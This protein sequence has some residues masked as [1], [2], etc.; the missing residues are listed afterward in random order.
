MCV[1]AVAAVIGGP[2]SAVVIQL[3]GW[4]AIVVPLVRMRTWSGRQRLPWLLC[5]AA[6]GLF[7]LGSIT[8]FVHAGLAGVDE[9]FP[10][11]AD[12]LFLTGYV[13]LI[14]GEL[15]LI[16]F[17]T[18]ET[19][20]DHM[21]DAAIVAA[22]VSLL[23]WAAILAP[24]VRDAGIP[25]AER[26]LNVGYSTL[27]LVL[28]TLTARLAVG[29]GIRNQ[30][31][32]LLAG[33]I[34]LIFITDLLAT[35]D[36]AGTNTER[37]VLALPPFTYVLFAAA[38]LH[39]SMVRLT[40][41]P[42]DQD[43]QLTW[44]R[45]LLLAA[46]LLV[47][48]GVLVWQI[49]RD[50]PID[51]PVVVVG[52]IVLSLL[53]LARLSGLVRA[54]ERNAI[55]ER[56]LREAGAALVVATSR[57]EILDGTLTTVLALADAGRGA[58]VTVMLGDET[59]LEVAASAGDGTPDPV[60]TRLPTGTFPVEIRDAL[61]ERRPV[62]LVGAP[63]AKGDAGDDAEAMLIVPLVSQNELRGAL[64]LTTVGAVDREVRRSIESLASEVALAL[65]S[66]ALTEDLLRRRSEARFRALIENSSDLVVVLDDEARVTFV[67]P[68]AH[69]LL[70]RSEEYF[71]G[72]EPMQFV[73]P[74][75]RGAIRELLDTARPL[76]APTEPLEIRLAHAD[77]SY[78][79]FEMLSHDLRTE[80]D[81][82]G[83]VIN[84]REITD[85]KGAEQLLARNE[86]RFR[87]LVQ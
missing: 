33:S 70:G 32:Y 87:A 71:S 68:A 10:S 59:E 55:R 19:E 60:G 2:V 46:A 69:R 12:A 66:A 9:P 18:L 51:L 77:G 80:P 3:T 23:A 39:P 26:Y 38:A 79:W 74:D 30:S 82:A 40:E 8:R 29:P 75:D 11:V 5:A 63:V 52:S 57:A 53:V 25:G 47:A 36:T 61:R 86:A 58:R 22:G 56:V 84:A 15:F 48:P 7:L 83:I 20:R 78:R 72:K 44:K 49:A 85:R 1:A 34:S 73:H 14:L 45:E 21:I 6:G 24:Y 43:V 42:P 41:A 17:R 67:S 81:I 16:R 64:A 54:K 35:L 27:T 62:R 65:E 4:T 13:A 28:L 76:S 31:Y 50:K 37:I